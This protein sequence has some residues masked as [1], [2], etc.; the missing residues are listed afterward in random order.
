M[1]GESVG[2]NE[3]LLEGLKEMEGLTLGQQE[4]QKVG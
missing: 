4:G 2:A 3:G 1:D